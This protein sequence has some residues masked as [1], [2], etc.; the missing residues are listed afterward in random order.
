MNKIEYAT[1]VTID[2]VTFIRDDAY[3]L[4]AGLFRSTERSGVRIS[5]QVRRT[6][7]QVSIGCVEIETGTECTLHLY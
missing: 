3:T 4:E 1:E 7:H 6:L 2:D 5:N